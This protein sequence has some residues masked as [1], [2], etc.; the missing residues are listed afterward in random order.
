[1]LTGKKT[2]DQLNEI[3]K[4]TFELCGNIIRQTSD[5][6]FLA[7]PDVL[8]V[9]QQATELFEM[10]SGMDMENDDRYFRVYALKSEL[11]KRFY[12]L[13]RIYGEI[14]ENVKK[15]A[16]RINFNFQDISNEKEMHTEEEI[17]AKLKTLLKQG[18]AIILFRAHTQSTWGYGDNISI[19]VEM[20]LYSDEYCK[21]L[22]VNE[23]MEH[24]MEGPMYLSIGSKEDE[25]YII[26][27]IEKLLNKQIGFFRQKHENGT[28]Q[29]NIWTENITLSEMLEIVGMILARIKKF[30]RKRWDGEEIKWGHR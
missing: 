29:R 16:A 17:M 26:D 3:E 13:S 1:M 9:R 25:P 12:E 28:I 4:D 23:F 19:Q 6:D 7:M 24:C 8:K 15:R 5:R 14:R 22:H 21:S 27:R 11:Q 20:P 10:A 30:P 18:E 2:T